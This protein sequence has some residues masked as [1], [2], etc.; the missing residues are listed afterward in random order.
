AELGCD[1]RLVMPAYPAALE[2]V[3]APRTLGE[4]DLQ[5]HGARVRIIAGRMP[6]TALPVWLIDA[7]SLYRRSGG[8]YQDADGRDWPD[9]ARRFGVFCHALAELAGPAV[10][11]TGWRPDVV[12]CND[13]HTGLLP[14]LLHGSP[15]KP[16]TVFTIHNLAFQGNFPL[17]SAATLAL[18]LE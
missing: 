10:A 17:A 13:W 14:L 2:Q 15:R 6:D 3:V 1:V 8:L 18:P 11:Q 12:H 5:A 16:R 7:P 9:N 4:I